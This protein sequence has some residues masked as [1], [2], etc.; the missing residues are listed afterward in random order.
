[1]SYV[2]YGIIIALL[3][4]VSCGFIMLFK[5]INDVEADLDSKS[6]IKRTPLHKVK[7]KVKDG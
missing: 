7:R 3:F 5:W 1:M 2:D 6:H 4:T